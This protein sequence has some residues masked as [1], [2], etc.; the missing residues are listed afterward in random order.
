MPLLRERRVAVEHL[1]ARSGG[2]ARHALFACKKRD[3]PE[4]TQAGAVDRAWRELRDGAW[5]Y[6]S[7]RGGSQAARVACRSVADWLPGPVLGCLEETPK[8]RWPAKTRL[9]ITKHYATR[10]PV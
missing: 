8:V 10:Y 7:A 3:S 1:L 4:R 9:Y 2:L 6:G 5:E